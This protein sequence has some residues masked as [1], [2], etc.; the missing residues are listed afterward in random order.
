LTAANREHI[1]VDLP[2]NT[3][4]RT[5]IIDAFLE[6]V[7]QFQDHP[8][9][10]FVWF[11]F[12]PYMVDPF[13][14]SV[15]KSITDALR[16]R[17]IF[18]SADGQ[19]RLP[20]Q[21]I[22]LPHEFCDKHD[23]PLIPDEFLGGLHYLSL[24]SY[25]VDADAPH[26]KRLGVRTMSSDDFI[27]GLR[28]MNHNIRDR[29]S[30]WQESV[31]HQ[32]YFICERRRKTTRNPR[33]V[34]IMQLCIL[35]LA[36]GT[37]TSASSEGDIL[38][39]S[40]TSNVPRELH[41]RL[42]I[43]D[44]K[45]NTLRYL[46]FSSLGVKRADPQA[47]ATKI[48]ELHRGGSYLQSRESFIQHARFLYDH[49]YS[50]GVPRPT[51][52]RVVAQE[53]YI[54]KGTEVYCDFPDIQRTIRLT[55]VLPAPA[56]FLH[57]DYLKEQDWWNWL[58]E[59]V[60]VKYFPCLVNDGDLSPTF[61]KLTQTTDTQRLLTLV[62]ESWSQWQG[63][64]STNTESRLGEIQVTCE[65][66]SKH[67]LNATYL[68]RPGLMKYSDLP[69][70]PVTNP[71]LREW[72]FLSDLGVTHQVDGNFFLKRLVRS[73]AEG[74][75]DEEMIRSLYEQIQARFEENTKGIL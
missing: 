6:A 75:N 10:K 17:K 59:D 19:Y 45:P 57:S 34:D 25:D 31:C 24:T 42:L 44:I 14:S 36:D 35:P 54:V 3:T 4:L 52:L 29:P 26:F 18:R 11:K 72:D 69:F 67:S 41:L 49:R 53:G 58:R 74:C 62:K 32:L 63:S 60:G 39:D 33:L 56:K 30:T 28:N 43:A 51:D 64:L 7:N 21:C 40:E 48:L 5:G 9:L 2:W 73:S 15:E 1:L 38:F 13:F 8:T 55:E 23:Q 70:L 12:L 65:D 37:W 68:R 16:G 47:I 50:K 27:T 66:G 20:S 71:E 46:L 61:L 22:I